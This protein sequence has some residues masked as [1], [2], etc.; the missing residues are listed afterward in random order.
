MREQ[1]WK[2]KTAV[3]DISVKEKWSIRTWQAAAAELEVGHAI[4][5]DRVID[6]ELRKIADCRRDRGQCAL[7]IVGDAEWGAKPKGR[8]VAPGAKTLLHRVEMAHQ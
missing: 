2:R 4:A 1:G 8:A 3:L 7:M 6:S 5:S